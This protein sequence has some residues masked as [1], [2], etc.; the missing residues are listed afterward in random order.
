VLTRAVEIEARLAGDE[1]LPR[2]ER[3]KLRVELGELREDAEDLRR[4]GAR[5][6]DDLEKAQR[7]FRAALEVEGTAALERL[8]AEMDK[9]VD[10]LLDTPLS[11]WAGR[12][13]EARLISA[14]ASRWLSSM[15]RTIYADTFVNGAF[16]LAA[17]VPLWDRPSQATVGDLRAWVT[18]SQRAQARLAA[19][20]A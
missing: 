4:E 13:A 17:R 12:L 8:C 5:L 20:G 11:K 6:E 9:I 15:G 3:K 19:E 2:E 7:A 18:K 16:P 14:L 1:D 10:A